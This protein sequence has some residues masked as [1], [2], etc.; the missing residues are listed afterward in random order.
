M[1]YNYKC[2]KCGTRPDSIDSD[3]NKITF[4]CRKKECLVSEVIIILNPAN[5]YY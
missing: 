5:R 2:P 3:S 1:Q 4:R